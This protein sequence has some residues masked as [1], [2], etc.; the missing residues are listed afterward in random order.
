MAVL[1][2]RIGG[3]WVPVGGGGGGGTSTSE[4]EI[5][6]TDPIGSNPAAELWYDT[7]APAQ[8]IISDE[9]RWNTAW[10]IVAVGTMVQTTG[11]TVPVTVVTPVTN[12]L[13]VALVAGRRYRVR[14]HARA[15]MSGTTESNVPWVLRDGAT[16][17]GG[18]NFHNNLPPTGNS[19][20]WAWAE[21]M[22]TGDGGTKA[23]NVVANGP[24]AAFTIYTDANAAFYV[25]DVGPVSLAAAVPNPTPAW[26]NMTLG[27][28]WSNLGGWQAAQYRKVGDVVQLRGLITSAGTG[29]GIW[30]SI[31]AGYG[32]PVQCILSAPYAP[33][34]GAHA[35]AR[36]DVYPT[37]MN[38]VAPV[39]Y[40]SLNDLTWSVTA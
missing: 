12:N 31:P 1:K 22:L 33:V 35:A 16:T 21:W 7:D 20:T 32:P 5:N 14:F 15:M 23:L 19:Y 3:V 9:A 37:F 26:I 29:V 40:L 24:G 34:S 28:G 18:A 4:V 36:I 38:G 13:S 10:G 17:V 6:A 39:N 30:S 2:A 25:E 8:P 27:S 11:W